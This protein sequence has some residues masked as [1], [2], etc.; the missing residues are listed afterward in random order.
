MAND[1]FGTGYQSGPY[2]GAGT[3]GAAINSASG[4]SPTNPFSIN[5]ADWLEEPGVGMQAAYQ[6][7]AGQQKA[8][9]GRK[10]YFQGQ[11]QPAMNEFLGQLGGQALGGEGA[12]GQA[13]TASWVDFLRGTKTDNPFTRMRGRSPAMRGEGR[14]STFAPRARFLYNY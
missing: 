7:F 8:P 1:F 5:Y 2:V 12:P 3:P 11:F 9:P 10:R 6:H 14:Q 13:P 4:S